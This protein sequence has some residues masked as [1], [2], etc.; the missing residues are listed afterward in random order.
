ML[1]NLFAEPKDKLEQYKLFT[2]HFWFGLDTYLKKELQ[3]LTM[4]RDPIQRTISYYYH[5]KRSPSGYR[6]QQMTQENWSLDD[7]VRH[8]ETNWDM[9]NCQT[10]F[11]AVD[12]DYDKLEK[13]PV[14]YGQ[15]IVKSYAHRGNDQELLNIAKQRLEKFIFVGITERMHESLLLLNHQMNWKTDVPDIKMNIGFNRVEETLS[16]DTISFIKEITQLDKALYDYGVLLFEE[17]LQ[18]MTKR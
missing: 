2:G 5:L 10:L 16:K 11:L 18:S 13:D 3:Y 12:L 4:L 7:F 1:P 17:R 6:Y 8:P 14:G 15:A 9:V